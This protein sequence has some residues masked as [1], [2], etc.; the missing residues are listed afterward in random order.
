MRKGQEMFNFLE[1]L[2]QEK[3]VGTNQNKRM[4]DP[5]NLSDYD[6]DRY[7]VEYKKTLESN[8]Q[9]T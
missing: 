5:F 8:K 6:W 2:H 4:A 1:W 9:L 3:G 7:M